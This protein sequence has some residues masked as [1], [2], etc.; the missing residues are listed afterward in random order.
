MNG[1][2]RNRRQATK[3]KSTDLVPVDNRI[4]MYRRLY[5]LSQWDLAKRCD[6]NGS[7]I[8]KIENRLSAPKITNAMTIAEVLKVPLQ[9]LFFREG[10]NPPIHLPE[11]LR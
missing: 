9:D 4:K 11:E 7:V 2:R 8:Y 3:R 6:L 10:E 5:N 1:F